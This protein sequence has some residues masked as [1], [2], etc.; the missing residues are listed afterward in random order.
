MIVGA[1]EELGKVA[2]EAPNV[3]SLVVFLLK[4]NDFRRPIP[5]WDYVGR[6]ASF[7]G[8]SLAGSLVKTDTLTRFLG[9][10]CLFQGKMVG[11]RI[12]TIFQLRKT[13]TLAVGLL[14]FRRN[15]S[16]KAK[17][18]NF[19]L[20]LVVYKDVGWFDIPV[21]YIGRMQ[22]VES[23][24]GVVDNGYDVILVK[25]DALGLRQDIS[26]IGFDVLH[27]DEHV[28]LA[29][30]ITRHDDIDQTSRENVIRHNT[31]LT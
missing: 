20:A 18:A 24:Q 1:V 6:E 12:F 4:E 29:L 5:P 3:D 19:D 2:A 30:I 21:H 15:G 17:I 31:H 14:D 7:L 8:A 28:A 11:S 16:R 27:H 25:R 23:T 9:R 22:K 10:A 13:T 26:Q